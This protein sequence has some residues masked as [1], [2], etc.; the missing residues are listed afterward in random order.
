MRKPKI[1]ARL[2][3]MRS[4]MIADCL[5]ST[6]PEQPAQVQ[7]EHASTKST[8]PKAMPR[9]ISAERG[10]RRHAGTRGRRPGGT[11]APAEVAPATSWPPSPTLW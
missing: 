2:A 5:R 10:S 3:P 6:Q 8:R 4:C 1:E 11:G 7:H 9:S